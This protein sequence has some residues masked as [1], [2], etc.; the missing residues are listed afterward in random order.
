MKYFNEKSSKG[1]VNLFSDFL[2]KEINKTNQH[3]V[4]IEVTDCGKFLVVNGM[5]SSSKILDMVQVKDNF[6]SEYETLLTDFG[7]S[8]INIIDLIMYEQELIKKFNHMFDFYNSSRPIYHQSIID[9]I[10]DTIQPKYNTLSFTNRMEYELDY[11]EDNTSN[12]SFYTY[13]PLNISS[14]FP[15]GYSLSMGRQELYYSEYICNQLFDTL[16]TN[17]ITFEYSSVV[18][19][20]TEDYNIKIVSNSIHPTKDIT[21]MIL[22][23]FDFDML[24]FNNTIKDYNILDDLLKPLDTKPWLIKDKIK[25]LILF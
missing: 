8:H 23:V 25:D 2:V 10:N 20:E 5:T 11:S 9:T 7:Y 3:D 4:V 19:D 1:I 12:L 16:L 21:S 6:V 15:H 18:L 13:S 22:D 24:K 14:E 17:Q